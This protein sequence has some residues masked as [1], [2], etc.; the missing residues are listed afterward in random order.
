[1]SHSNVSD[2]KSELSMAGEKIAPRAETVAIFASR[3]DELTSYDDTASP[4][5]ATVDGECS[6]ELGAARVSP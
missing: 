1:M 5:T 3:G 4:A 2:G 6:A